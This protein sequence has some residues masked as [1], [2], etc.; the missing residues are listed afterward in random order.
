LLDQR[1]LALAMA[2][3]TQVHVGLARY[4]Y[5]ANELKTAGDYHNTQSEIYRQIMA[6]YDSGRVSR[7]TLIRERMN[8]AISDVKYDIAYADL[9]NAY[10][11][12]FA[13]IGADPF[14]A[15]LR[16]DEPVVE[17][18]AS[19]RSLWLSRGDTRSQ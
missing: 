19:L 14:D 15:D 6:S 18:A 9:Q 8:K 4:D 13:A 2:V 3:M 17:M 1:A 11:N 16:G 5:L 10:A 12:V 7:Q